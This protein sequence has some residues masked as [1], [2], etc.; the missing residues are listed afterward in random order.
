MSNKNKVK[1]LRGILGPLTGTTDPIQVD[2]NG[3]VTINK[4]LRSITKK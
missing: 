1:Q 4:K 2:K 3:V